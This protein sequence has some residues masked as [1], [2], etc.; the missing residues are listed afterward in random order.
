MSGIVGGGGVSLSWFRDFRVAIVCARRVPHA[1]GRRQ[2]AEV[3]SV[4]RTVFTSA[5][6]V[7]R[8][9]SRDSFLRGFTSSR[10]KKKSHAKTRR[11]RRGGN[12][13]PQRIRGS[14]C[15]GREVSFSA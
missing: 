8:V 2:K 10:E 1:E 9:S 4:D 13:H 3:L 6:E 12:D 15:H 5:P 11:T 14:D 7:P